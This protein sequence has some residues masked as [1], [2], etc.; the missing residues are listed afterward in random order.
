MAGLLKTTAEFFASKGVDEARFGAE[1][2]LSHVLG[3]ERIQ[4]YLQ[5]ERPVYPDELERFRGL[6]R[7]RLAGRPIQYIIGE[8]WFYGRPFRV[9][10]RVLIPRPETELLVEHALE[11]LAA[12]FPSGEAGPR[13]LD[14]GTG[15]G[16]VALTMALQHPQLHADA[17]DLSEG[18]LEVASAN[19]ARHGVADRVSFMAGDMT[20]AALALPDAPFDM[21]VSNPP[22]IPESEWEGLQPEVRDHEPKLALIVPEGMECYRA[23]ASLGQRMLRPGGWLAL[24]IHAD[25]AAGVQQL[26]REA[27]F[28]EIALV[29]DYSGLDRIVSGRLP[30]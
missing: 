15:S 11:L 5:Y 1:L 12:D 16:C 22:Y 29:K 8:Q 20:D 17:L 4:L 14:A 27:G 13:I 21:I 25:G 10:S 18:A 23:L 7:E 24:E 9:D 6:C 3:T 19:A 28:R 2:L 26:L 30:D